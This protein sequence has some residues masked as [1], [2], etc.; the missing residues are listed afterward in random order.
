MPEYLEQLDIVAQRIYQE[1]YGFSVCDMLI[2][3][4]TALDSVSAG[5]GG[6]MPGE[7][8]GQIHGYDTIYVMLHGKKI[9]LSFLSFGTEKKLASVV[10][11]LSRNHP[12]V[13]LSRRD[14]YIV[15]GLPCRIPRQPYGWR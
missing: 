4:E 15:T 10:K 13:Q 2:S 14:C 12:R 9:R 7:G 3:N 8:A 1:L 11:K 5:C 6:G